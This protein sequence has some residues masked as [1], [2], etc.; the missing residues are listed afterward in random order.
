MAIENFSK[1]IDLHPE[2]V[3]AYGN[4]GISYNDK[5]DFERALNDYN[6]AIQLAPYFEN[7]YNNRG[8][9]YKSLGRYDEAISDFLLAHD[10]NPKLEKAIGNLIITYKELNECEKVIKW[11]DYYLK[12]Y[13]PRKIVYSTRAACKEHLGN[14]TGAME[15]YKLADLTINKRHPDEP[16]QYDNLTI[17]NFAFGVLAFLSVLG[18]FFSLRMRN[19]SKTKR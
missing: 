2:Y 4:R 15:D 7:Y 19:I 12:L 14:E 9:T 17:A 16:K 1:A 11:C 18:I 5:G 13:S 3:K 8:F 6:M 10:L